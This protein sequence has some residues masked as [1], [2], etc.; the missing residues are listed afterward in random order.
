MS[1]KVSYYYKEIQ[2]TFMMAGHLQTEDLT[3]CSS[4]DRKIKTE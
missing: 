1:I 3:L 4:L 2:M